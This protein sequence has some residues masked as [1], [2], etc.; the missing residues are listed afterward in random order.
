MGNTVQFHRVLRAAPEKVYRAFL[1]ADATM[2]KRLPPNG[3][4]GKVHHMDARKGTAGLAYLAIFT[5]T[6]IVASVYLM[7]IRPG[8]ACSADAGRPDRGDA[9]ETEAHH[10]VRIDRVHRP[11]RC[12]GSRCP[13]RVAQGAA[14]RRAVRRRARRDRVQ[15]HRLRL[16]REF[17]CVGDDR[18]RRRPDGDLDGSVC[19]AHGARGGVT[20]DARAKR[21]L[22]KKCVNEIRRRPSLRRFTA[23]TPL[24][25]SHARRRRRR[26]APAR[27]AAGSVCSATSRVFQITAVAFVHLLEPLGRRRPQPH[28]GERRLDRVRRPQMLPVL[29]A[30]TG[31][32]SPSGPSPR[33]RRAPDLRVAALRRPRLKR[34][35]LPLGLLARLGIGDLRQQTP[36]LGLQPLSGSLSRTFT[37]RWFQHRCSAASG[38]TAA[39]APQIPRCPSPITSR[40]A[41]SPRA[42]RSRKQRGPALGRLPIPTL[43]RQDRPSGRRAAPPI[44]TSIAALSFSSP[45]LT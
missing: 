29:A 5:G 31:R 40:G 44:S 18:G 2:V 20:L 38:N 21:G 34:P 28:R 4:T 30:G 11:P 9:A 41:P 25:Y 12:I 3:F 43:H 1:D 10:A 13:F 26:A 33:S 7:K 15:S 35:L 8:A 16:L 17:L 14:R 24:T 22:V 23:R 32:T 45:A 19:D 42:L 6:S 27:R 37:I 39:S 36:G